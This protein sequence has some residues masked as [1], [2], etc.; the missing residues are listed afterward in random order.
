MFRF[1]NEYILYALFLL[2]VWVALYAYIRFKQKKIW[3]N[4]GDV[5]LLK[6]MLPDTSYRMKIL[7]FIILCLIYIALIFSLANPELGSNIEKS[8]RKGIDIMF[9][10]DVSNSMLARDLS[11]NRLEASKISI[12]SLLDRLKGDRVGLVVFAGKSFVQLPITSDYAA[13]KTFINQL[14]TQMISEQGTDIGTAI[15]LAATSMLPAK[16]TTSNPKASP[17]NVNKVIVVISD[18]E[19]HWDEVVDIAKAASKKGIRIFTIGIGSVLGEPIPIE[20]K[21]GKIQYKKDKDGNTVITRL[22]EKMLKD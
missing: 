7:K 20:T 8:K 16:T 19:D 3:A 12:L 14:S 15:D 22:N 1:E 21:G 10:V 5:Q 4:Y 18:G 2:P 9:C 6:S 13:A 11:P 17:T